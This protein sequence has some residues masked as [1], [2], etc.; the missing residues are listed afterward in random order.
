M[1]KEFKKTKPRSSLNLYTEIKVARSAAATS[2]ITQSSQFNLLSAFYTGGNFNPDIPNPSI[3]VD[4]DIGFAAA[5]GQLT[6]QGNA[7]FTV[8]AFFRVVKLPSAIFADKFSLILEP[9]GAEE[10]IC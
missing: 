5:F 7:V 6:A 9:D 2:R 10:L 4:F 3:L 1:R 8:F